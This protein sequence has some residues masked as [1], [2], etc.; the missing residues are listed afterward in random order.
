MKNIRN[1]SIIAHIDHGKST[2]AD[3]FIQFCKGL[4]KREMSD[5]IL[6]SMDIEKE[7]GI[8]IKAQ[9]VSLKYKSKKSKIF[10][11]NLIDTPGHVD[12]SYEVSRSLSACE[13]AIL[14][15]DS[16]QGVE[17][18]TLAN[19]NIALEMNLKVI[20]VLNKIDLP[21]S[22][23]K[24]VLK[25][26]EQIIGIKTLNVTR[27]SAKTGY[28]ITDL[29]EKIIEEIP[30]PKGSSL[31][32][33][34]ALILDSWFDKYLG[35]ISLI[36]IKEGKIKVGDKIK[37][38]ST[39]Q[40]FTVEKLGTFTPKKQEKSKLSCGSVGWIVCG[41]KNILGAPIGDTITTKKNSAE[42]PLPGFK[43]IK[44]QIYAGLFPNDSNYYEHFRNSLNKLS[45]NDSSLLYEPENSIALGFGFRCGFLGLLHMEIVKERLEREYNLDL[46]ST[47]PTVNYEI[48]LNDNNSIIIDNPIK[49]PKKNL[50]KAI[51]EPI[52]KCNILSPIKYV[53]NIISLCVDRRGIQKNMIY[54]NDQVEL[55]YEIPMSEVILNFFDSLKSISSGYASLKYN[56]LKFKKSNVVRLDILINSDRIDALSIIIHKS[57]AIKK[58]K[59]IVEN[60]KNII[61]RHQFNIII[62]ASIENN[63]IARETIK[64]LRK[65][66][67]AKCYGGDISRKKKLIQKQK[68]GKKKMKKIGNIQIPQ[69]VF[70]TILGKYK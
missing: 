33:L 17:A 36:R 60:I 28:G 25:E 4:T 12:F 51:K 21:T 5:Q 52:A 56:F 58:A 46:I 43:V 32:K 61:P 38:M 29:L 2:I 45:L 55:I 70:L 40:S 37:I 49:L 54:H 1:F 35:V 10:K 41:I 69:E 24:K 63:I 27:C 8:T 57:N 9:S 20:P 67:I 59:K 50:I 18:Q 16:T 64:Q 19:C 3:R 48:E 23:P 13:G 22:N 34:Q 7:R 44:P 30:Y 26:I 39:N 15:I 6:D 62:Q 66:V 53:G 42:L 31:N 14:I 68:Y 11:L 47:T 65:N